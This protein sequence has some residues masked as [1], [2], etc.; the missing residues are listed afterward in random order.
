M[1][2]S[3][4]CRKENWHRLQGLCQHR[5]LRFWV[6]RCVSPISPVLVL[7]RQDLSG[8]PYAASQPL[9]VE[10]RLAASRWWSRYA[11]NAPC[12][13]LFWIDLAPLIGFRMPMSASASYHHRWVCD[14]CPSRGPSNQ[15]RY[16]RGSLVWT[17]CCQSE[18]SPYRL[19]VALHRANAPRLCARIFVAVWCPNALGTPLQIC[20]HPPM[21][22]RVWWVAHP[23]EWVSILPPW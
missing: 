19:G 11:P 13:S 15:K 9:C 6:C 22:Y 1:I 14:S 17:I 20:E 4:R 7:A 3:Y 18:N 10:V 12:L 8:V 23:H 21:W 5:W 16:E 2:S